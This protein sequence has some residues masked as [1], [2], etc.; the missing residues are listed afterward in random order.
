MYK[1][2]VLMTG[3][4]GF[5]GSHLV[6]FLLVRDYAVIGLTRQKNLRNAHPDFHWVHDLDELKNQQ[7]DYVINLAGESIGQG[8]WTTA[9]KKKLMDSRLKTT[10][11]LFEHLEKYQ[12]KPKRIISAS[13]VGYYGIDPEEQWD[14]VCTEHSPAQDIFMSELCAE[15]ERLALSYPEQNTKI[16]RL[17]VV[18]AKGGGI[19]PQMLLPI[20]LNLF[21]RMGH[22]RQ[23]VTWVHLQDVM[24]AIE[25][26]MQES[27]QPQ[28]FNLVAPEKV[29]QAQFARIA[30]QVLKRK[31]LLPLPAC[32]M[33]MLLGEQSQL[34]LN[35]Q[36]V[37]PKAL[38]EAGFTFSYPTLKEALLEV[39]NR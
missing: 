22:G 24:R 3:A 30:A 7:I 25:F 9:R 14:R 38:Q 23:P 34:I 35:G 18:F 16:I 6:R 4:S 2:V 10:R 21:G 5:I 28:I 15:W 37:Q 13:A 31:P 39:L 1:P 36:Y 11:Q 8:R 27:T 20:K 32:S 29:S 17:G 12:I 33:K 19:L 26:L